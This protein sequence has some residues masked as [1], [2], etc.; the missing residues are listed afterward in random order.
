VAW[1]QII[2]HL[3]PADLP[4]AEALLQLAGA[5][6]VSLHDDGD[7]PV[8]EPRPGETPLW[9]AVVVRALF[10]RQIDA[11]PLVDVLENALGPGLEASIETLDDDDWRNAW[12]ETIVSRSIGRRL[13]IVAA[14]DVDDIDVDD[15]AVVVALRMGLAFG[16]GAHPTTALCLEWLDA[17]SVAG[18]D[19]IDYGCGSGVLAIAALKL[20]AAS[21]WAV[22]DNAKAL[23]ATRDNA[24][25][26]GVDERLW[27]GSPDALP[28]VR[29]DLVLANILAG[30][31][32]RL[33]DELAERVVARGRIVLS[34]LLV[35]QC[36]G[37][38]RAYRPYFDSFCRATDDGWARLDAVRNRSA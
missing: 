22:D 10:P 1:Q 34:G 18:L 8:L 14:D 11:T 28:D 4:R 17:E 2:L 19:V 21:A 30:T 13:R 20:G 29:A 38:E 9:P 5:V 15:D 32:E 25:L 23:A 24:R 33:A 7:A 35:A 3:T 16:T 31:L 6:A 36:D 27:V 26:N 37:V 12:R